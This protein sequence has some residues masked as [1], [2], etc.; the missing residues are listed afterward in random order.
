MEPGAFREELLQPIMVKI[1]P[2]YITI[3]QEPMMFLL[4]CPM[5]STNNTLTKTGYIIVSGIIADFSG[6]PAT[7][8]VGETVTFTNIVILFTD[9][10]ELV[11]L[12][13][14]TF[15]SY[16]SGTTCNYL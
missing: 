8:S 6:S 12:R 11:I 5:G 14:N 13:W 3:L 4:P 15:N 2:Q 10:V 9:L 16:R 1:H 7:V